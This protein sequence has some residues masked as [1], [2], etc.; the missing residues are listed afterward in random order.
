[1]FWNHRAYLKS[2]MLILWQLIIANWPPTIGFSPK[3]PFLPSFDCF[4]SAA[5]LPRV[6]VLAGQPSKVGAVASV[7]APRPRPKRSP[8]SRLSA[9]PDLVYLCTDGWEAEA[10]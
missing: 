9:M 7:N 8:T 1:M 4:A 6:A 2:M 5:G 3:P 10:W